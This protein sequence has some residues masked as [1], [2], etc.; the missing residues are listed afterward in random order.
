MGA[1]LGKAGRGE[2]GGRQLILLESQAPPEA[3]ACGPGASQGLGCEGLAVFAVTCT[4][5]Q[6][7][8]PGTAPTV[9]GGGASGQ[10][11]AVL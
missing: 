8:P 10:V 2:R 3:L 1:G 4:H 5:L 9:G 7:Q 11:P 6:A